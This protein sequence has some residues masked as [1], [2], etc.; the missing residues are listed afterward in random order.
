MLGRNKQVEETPTKNIPILTIDHFPGREYDVIDSLWFGVE[1]E[2]L[3]KDSVSTGI[4]ELKNGI[5]QV[6]AT[7]GAD[8]V[9][10]F[11]TEAVRKY[12]GANN[13]S[14]Q[15]LLGYGTGIKFK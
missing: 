3:K 6:A 7:Q 12:V 8:A 4:D 9:I 13:S 2:I 11:R 1:L 10:G 15:S 5:K 14:A